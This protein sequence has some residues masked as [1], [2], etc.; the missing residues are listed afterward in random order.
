MQRTW[1]GTTEKENTPGETV[2]RL[3]GNSRQETEEQGSR[4]FGRKK[5]GARCSEAFQEVQSTGKKP[6]S[7]G[8]RKWRNLKTTGDC[9]ELKCNV[10]TSLE[11]QKSRERGG[12]ASQK[13]D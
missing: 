10:E 1:Q 8:T 12:F 5:L 4:R 3:Q 11:R 13:V 9:L 7:P 6:F 2:Y